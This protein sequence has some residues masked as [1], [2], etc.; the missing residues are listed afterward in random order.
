[1]CYEDGGTVDDLL[2]Y[3]KEKNNYLL[4]INASNIEK[5]VDWLQKH[6]GEED[7]SIKMSLIKLPC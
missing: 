1:M 3:Q 7:V 4:V 6:Q 5:D 2:V